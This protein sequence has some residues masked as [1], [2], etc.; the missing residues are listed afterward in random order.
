MAFEIFIDNIPFSKQRKLTR[1]SLKI[2]EFQP[3][4]RDFAFVVEA[5]CEVD[6]IK[7]AIIASSKELITEVRVFD[8]FEGK[9]AEN[10]LGKGKKSVAFMVRLQPVSSTFTDNDLEKISVNIISNVENASG[11]YLRS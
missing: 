6:L 11:G 8:I 1:A 7:K 2:S 9:E 10:Q 4:E 5:G 3:V